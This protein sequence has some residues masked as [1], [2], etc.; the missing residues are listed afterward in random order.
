M[1]NVRRGVLCLVMVSLFSVKAQSVG[2]AATAPQ[3]AQAAATVQSEKLVRAGL[4]IQ[5]GVRFHGPDAFNDFVTD[6]WNTFLVENVYTPADEKSIGP[7]VFLA[8][9]GSID[10]GPVFSA[11][12]FVQGMWAGKQFLVRG[13]R[14]GDVHINT[15]TA[16]GGLNLW[17][18]AVTTG[19]FSLRAGA[20][21]YATHTIATITGDI[22]H[23]R[24]SATGAGFKGLLGTEFRVSDN[25][26]VTL[27][28]GVPFGKSDFNK[29]DISV[30]GTDVD[31]PEEF[32]YLGFEISPGI[33]FYF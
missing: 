13:G 20:G 32:D 8:I 21:V 16:M 29:G 19:I 5:C 33:R 27:D 28:F 17:A 25:L 23:D 30:C 12:P 7:G 22:T 10:I 31:Y 3:P 18:R 9:N 2:S 15:Y 26:M 6:V 14:V 1:H 4:G 11:S 24:I